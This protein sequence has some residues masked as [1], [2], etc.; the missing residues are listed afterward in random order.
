MANEKI[1]SAEDI[2]HGIDF[3]K[4]YLLE[5]MYNAND[6]TQEGE[7]DFLK[8]SQ[9]AD[10]YERVIAELDNFIENAIAGEPGIDTFDQAML[11]ESAKETITKRIGLKI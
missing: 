11:H 3:C 1:K 5:A 10:Y 9:L 7:E 4:D 8:N 6:R 2:R